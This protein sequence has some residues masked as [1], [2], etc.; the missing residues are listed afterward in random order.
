SR[1]SQRSNARKTSTTPKKATLSSLPRSPN[2]S[3]PRCRPASEAGE[4]PEGRKFQAPNSKK[5]PNSK[6][7]NP[8]KIACER[9]RLG[10]ASRFQ[11]AVTHGDRLWRRKAGGDGICGVPATVCRTDGRGEGR[12]RAG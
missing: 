7:Q 11:W 3:K 8:S 2:L 9:R 4:E 5:A 6:L 10:G 1:N 12:L